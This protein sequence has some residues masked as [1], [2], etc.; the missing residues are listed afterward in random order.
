VT[1]ALGEHVDL[2]AVPDDHHRDLVDEPL[3]RAV[4]RQFRGWHQVIPAGRDQMWHRFS[5]VG[6]AR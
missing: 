5:L 4:V 2:P 3:H 1:A 6:A